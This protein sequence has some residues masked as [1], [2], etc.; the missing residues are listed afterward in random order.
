[1]SGREL[2]NCYYE[3]WKIISDY[4][5]WVTGGGESLYGSVEVARNWA[6]A[7][8]AAQSSCF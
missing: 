2:F 8:L 1:M 7:L 6:G 5:E 3:A 4:I